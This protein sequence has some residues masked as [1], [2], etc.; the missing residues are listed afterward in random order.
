MNNP[1]VNLIGKTISNIKYFGGQAEIETSD[2]ESGY[3]DAC[4]PS[5]EI[6]RVS[7]GCVFPSP[8]VKGRSPDP[9]GA[10]T[11][12]GYTKRVTEVNQLLAGIGLSASA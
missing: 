5:P 6:R 1:F 9:G 4:G 12:A 2:G 3:I 10:A 7:L 8:N 11:N